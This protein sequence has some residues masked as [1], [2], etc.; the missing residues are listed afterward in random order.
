MQILIQWM[1]QN[2]AEIFA[3]ILGISGVWLTTRQNLWCWP[4]GLA[5]V[6]LSAWVF[7][8]ARLYADVVLQ[9]F[10]FVTT[11]YGWYQWKFG[12]KTKSGLK[13]SRIPRLLLLI[14]IFSGFAAVFLSGWLFASFTN[15]S[16]PYWD[17]GVAVWGVI[18]TF[19]M[20]RK[21]LESWTLWILIDSVCVG[22]YFY[23]ELYAFTA[24]YFIFVLLAVYGY[25]SW[26]KDLH[27]A[28]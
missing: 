7:F 1:L 6:I 12:G 23:K 20:A 9:A 10:Y 11:L 17:A 25:I 15:A 18:A 3:A 2:P 4:V 19:A 26:K 24:L 14:L 22:I 27:T 28:Q 16:L 13:V 5:N 8:H 21:Y